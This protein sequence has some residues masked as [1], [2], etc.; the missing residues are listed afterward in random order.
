M[1]VDI[2]PK[3][4]KP[5][6]PVPISPRLPVEYVCLLRLSHAIHEISDNPVVNPYSTLREFQEKNARY[7]QIENATAYGRTEVAP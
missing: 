2:F 5:K 6:V 3:H 7:S 4:L 1:W